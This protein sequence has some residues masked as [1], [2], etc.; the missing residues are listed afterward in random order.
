[1]AACHRQRDPQ[2]FQ[3]LQKPLAEALMNRGDKEK[4]IAYYEKSLALNPKN[5][6]AVAMLA[7][8]RE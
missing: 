5:M 2:L 3:Q 1:L 7:K 8:L 4:A 6:N